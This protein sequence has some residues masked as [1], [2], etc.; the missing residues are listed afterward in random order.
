MSELSPTAKIFDAGD[1]LGEKY[2]LERLL[3]EGGMGQVWL[4]RNE[5]LDLPVALKILRREA[6][7]EDMAARLLLEARVEAKLQHPNVVRVFDCGTTDDGEPYIVMELLE[8]VSLGALLA[9]RTTLAPVEAVQLLLPVIDGLCAAHRAGVVHR[10]LK[11]DNIFIVNGPRHPIPKILDF[12]IAKLND[13]AT[14][15]LTATGQV[16]GSPA[17]MSPEQARGS[18]DIDSRADIWAM[19]VVLY[20]I[21]TGQP[22]FDG[23]NY[24][25]VLRAVIECEPAALQLP[26]CEELWAIVRRGLLKRRTERCASMEELGT[27]LAQWLVARGVH[28]DVSGQSLAPRWLSPGELASQPSAAGHARS[29]ELLRRFGV[30]RSGVGRNVGLYARHADVRATSLRQAELPLEMHPARDV[31]AAGRQA[32][33]A[34]IAVAHHGVLAPSRVAN[35]AEAGLLVGKRG[36]ASRRSHEVDAEHPRSADRREREGLHAVASE[37]GSASVHYRERAETPAHSASR[38]DGFADQLGRDSDDGGERGRVRADAG[39]RADQ[40]VRTGESDVERLGSSADRPRRIGLRRRVFARRKSGPR[41][42]ASL[43]RLQRIAAFA[44][45]LAVLLAGAKLM[46]AHYA[47]EVK[48]PTEHI[49]RPLPPPAAGPGSK[50]ER[51]VSA[52]EAHASV[53]RGDLQSEPS[54]HQLLKRWWREA[55]D[56]RQD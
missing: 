13:R 19:C 32:A 25:A 18:V 35:D 38:R 24:N 9:T 23:D 42:D 30:Q 56:P 21:V 10:D 52:P 20:E 14:R 55:T 3:G 34:R 28:E 31:A 49:V 1:L 40:T 8:G 12:G 5:P 22:A 50:R 41:A 11:P 37:R 29:A 27:S 48:L 43:H 33:F 44:L 53:E 2:R 6:L 51:S 54:P 36:G 39:E 15:H 16:L 26:G 47:A 7:H 4:A 45:I 17:Y 46:H